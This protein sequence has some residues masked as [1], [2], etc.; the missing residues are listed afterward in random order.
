MYAARH[1]ALH[2]D[3]PA[4]IMAT[5]GEV[6]TFADYEAGANRSAHLLRETGVRRRDHIAIFMENDARMLDRRGGAERTRRCYYTCIN[7]YLSAE[8]VAYI[9][10][11]SR[12]RS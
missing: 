7:S 4:I 12:R 11:D 8:E 9:I 10:N 2:P 6:V 5:S 1:A 3:K